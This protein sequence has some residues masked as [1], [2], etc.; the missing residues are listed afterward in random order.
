MDA[1]PPSELARNY[2][3]SAPKSLPKRAGGKE[4]GQAPAIAHLTTNT[5]L[6]KRKKGGKA[7]K[8][9]KGAE[10][11]PSEGMATPHYAPGPQDGS[12]LM[13]TDNVQYPFSNLC[14]LVVLPCHHE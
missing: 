9:A 11:A 4:V 12:E 10:T 8:K 3:P 2:P 7:P 13:D 6:L 14:S 1:E 5:K